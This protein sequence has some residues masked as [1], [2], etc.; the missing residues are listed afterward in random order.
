MSKV[1]NRAY[2]NY[3]D[4]VSVIH[5]LEAAGI[6]HND[7]SIVANNVNDDN[8]PTHKDA[9]AKGAGGGAAAGGTVGAGAGLLAGLGML[10][11]PGVGPVVAAG[12]LIAAAAGAAA[13][14]A[15]GATAGGIIGKLNEY[16]VSDEEAHFYLEVIRRGGALVSAKVSDDDAAKTTQIMDKAQYID[17]PSRINAY[18]GENWTG[19]SE[20]VPVFTNEQIAAERARYRS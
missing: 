9:V 16:E 11:I 6:S 10:A 7:I 18:R 20:T 14:A 15:A 5:Q 12:W 19:Y 3:A 13:S 17:V 2:E 1:I 8:D 4:A